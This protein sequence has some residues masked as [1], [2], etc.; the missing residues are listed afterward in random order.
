MVVKIQTDVDRLF[1]VSTII[2]FSLY[3]L[4]KE[5]KKLNLDMRVHVCGRYILMPPRV[6]LCRNYDFPMTAKKKTLLYQV[7][8]FSASKLYKKPAEL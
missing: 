7:L 4:L 6:Y 8:C 3:I 5:I 1:S 2:K